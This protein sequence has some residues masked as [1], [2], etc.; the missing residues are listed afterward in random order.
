MSTTH[1]T[2]KRPFIRWLAATAAA[3]TA[4]TVLAACGDNSEQATS[5]GAS[6]SPTTAA[7]ITAGAH[8]ATDVAF[9]KDM[10]PHHRQAVQMAD[11]APTRASSP[12]VKALAE[13]I[14]KAQDPEI[15][16]MSGW[17]NA[18][19][20]GVPQDSGMGMDHSG[21]D[22]S[23]MKEM[24][25]MMTA[26]EMQKLE[27]ASGPAFDTAFLQMM[28]KHHRGAV[29]MARNEKA[30]GS[31]RPAIKLADSIITSQTAEIQQMTKLLEK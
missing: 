11:L 31:Y 30:K 16:T 26:E 27:G 13:T 28:I 1:A 18:W 8:N 2:S 29:E 4:V 12:E 22:H 10:I 5:E 19:G 6:P 25:G 3:G 17:L 20:E 7:S 23:G 14:K 15:K 9:A 24:P 21:M